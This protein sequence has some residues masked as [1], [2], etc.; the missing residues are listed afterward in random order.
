MFERLVNEGSTFDTML[1]TQRR[2]HP[3]ISHFANMLF[4]DGKLID[5][6]PPR[7]PVPGFPWP[8][9]D[10]RVCL[11]NTRNYGSEK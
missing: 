1:L 8:T 7:L 2:M 11:V 10:C 6:P 5:N 9:N 3:S 4:Y